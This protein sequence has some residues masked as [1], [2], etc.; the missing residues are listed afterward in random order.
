MDHTNPS[1]N[2]ALVY[3]GPRQL[4]WEEWPI[5]RPGENEVVVEV[6]AVGICG[7][8]LHGYTGESGR[9]IPPMVMGH[10]AAGEV[11]EIGA[12]VNPSWAGKRVIIQPFVAE[13][14]QRGQRAVHAHPA[15][16]GSVQRRDQAL[17]IVARHLS[18]LDLGQSMQIDNAR[19]LDQVRQT[20]D[21][22]LQGTLERR[23]GESFK[24]VSERLEQVHKGL[25]EMQ[26]LATGVGDLKRVLSNVKARGTWAEVQLRAILEQTLA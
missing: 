11:I 7:S 4:S 3:H 23:L 19:Q 26:S 15:R 1:H 17:E 10:E 16:P 8:D 14:Q 2:K 22:K 5:A 12:G 9:R 13:V 20:V 18:A 6:R 25:G 24:Q 21:E